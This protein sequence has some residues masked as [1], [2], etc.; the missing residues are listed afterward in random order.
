MISSPLKDTFVPPW[1]YSNHHVLHDLT[2]W[3]ITGRTWFMKIWLKVTSKIGVNLNLNWK[4]INLN[5]NSDF[6]HH[7]LNIRDQNVPSPPE[8]PVLFPRFT[9]TCTHKQGCSLQSPSTAQ[10]HTI[11]R[12]FTSYANYTR[13]P[14]EFEIN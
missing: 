3:E 8:E 14:N 5:E 2:K 4:K 1:H 6:N 9:H 7:G 10:W 12:P 13:C 11:H